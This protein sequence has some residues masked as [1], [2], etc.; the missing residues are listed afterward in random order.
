MAEAPLITV[1]IVTYNSRAHIKNALASLMDSTIAQRLQVIVV[2]NASQDGTAAVV[3]A[4]FPQVRLI[5]LS[6]NIGFGSGHNRVL[7]YLSAPYHVIMN[8]DITLAP[9]MLEKMAAYM[10]GRPEAALLTPR[11][12]NPDGSE[13]FLPKELPSVR[14][15]LG[16]RLEKMGRPFAAWRSSYTWREKAVTAP[17]ELFFATGCF[18]FMR[19]EAFRAAGGFDQRFFLYMEDADLTRRMKAQ[20]LTLYHP[21]FA[22]THV[23]AREDAHSLKGLS[24]H[25][26]SMIRYFQKWGFRL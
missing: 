3:E 7:Q 9:D 24:L 22:V 8:P 26:K 4:E 2:D 5:R 20:G 10:A 16:G 13:Q 23:W 15:M 14:Y 25:V 12:L 11:V 17:A 18:M 1:C 6:E 21:G 19:T